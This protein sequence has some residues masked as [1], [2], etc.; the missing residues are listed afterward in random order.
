MLEAIEC[1]VQRVYVFP[2]IHDG[3]EDFIA[4]LCMYTA[5]TPSDD[6]ALDVNVLNPRT[7]AHSLNHSGAQRQARLHQSAR[8][9]ELVGTGTRG[10][11]GSGSAR[12]GFVQALLPSGRRRGRAPH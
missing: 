9:G 4:A 11:A 5:H 2:R 3:F 7:H 8:R 10:Q 6:G 12:G 1:R